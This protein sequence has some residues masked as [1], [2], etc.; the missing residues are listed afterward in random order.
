MNEMDD[1]TR[2]GLE[3][4]TDKA[5]WHRYTPIYY[6]YFKNIRHDE[7][8]ILEIGIGSTNCPSIKMLS[9]FFK[10]SKIYTIDIVNEFVKAAGKVNNTTSMVCDSSNKNELLKMFGNMRFDLIIDDGSHIDF[11]QKSAFEC[12]FPLLKPNGIYIC[13]DLHPSGDIDNNHM[14]Q[15]FNGH[16]SNFKHI[17]LFQRTEHAMQCFR[18]KRPNVGNSNTCACGI[19][20]APSK[21]DSITMIMVKND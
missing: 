12:L 3:Y 8:V 4:G 11:H 18:C 9:D 2:Y 6:E 20:F 10:N 16:C 5:Y 1:L 17:R 13:E 21:G 19:N 14:I 15:Y 7:N